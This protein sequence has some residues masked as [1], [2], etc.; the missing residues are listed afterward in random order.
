MSKVSDRI[1]FG[2]FEYVSLPQ[3][4]IHDAV[5]KIDTG[6]YSGALHCS[7]V[8]VKEHSD[9]RKTL[10][11]VPSNNKDCEIA[12]DQFE[13]VIVTSSTGH[14]VGRYLIT[15]QI[16]IQGKEYLITIGLA[17][18]SNMQRE[19]LIGRRFL[20]ENNILV[21]TR[22]RQELDNDGGEKV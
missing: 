21:D 14:K 8:E 15:T 22:I 11:F 20:R 16:T 19:I 4:G 6:A 18:R 5:A 2:S 13:D 1:V 12:T 7:K 10:H 3:F 17:D 9:G